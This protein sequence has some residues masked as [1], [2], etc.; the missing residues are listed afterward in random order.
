MKERK[1]YYSP[2]DITIEDR[3][4]IGDLAV[5]WYSG[6]VSHE[7]A[8][9][10]DLGCTADRHESWI[11]ISNPRT[12]S[13]FL[14]RVINISCH[15]SQEIKDIFTSVGHSAFEINPFSL[16][17]N[18]EEILLHLGAEHKLS[19]VVLGK[20]LGDER[21]IPPSPFRL[22]IV[23]N[24]ELTS[25]AF[26]VFSTFF[27]KQDEG[28]NDGEKRFVTNIQ[29]GPHIVAFD[30]CQPIGMIGSIVYGEIASVYAGIINPHY[31]SGND[32]SLTMALELERKLRLQGVNFIYYKSRN[33]A[34]VIGARMFLGLNHLYNERVYEKT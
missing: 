16:P 21:T 4:E 14:N 23:D 33:R 22:E 17:Y 19:S 10:E 11:T 6:I 2:S 29:R 3:I 20:E 26:S 18:V 34:V 15:N 8:G 24:E 12:K 28:M 7:I 30:D 32:L 13:M 5:K 27:L 9:L 1:L 31:R 25:S